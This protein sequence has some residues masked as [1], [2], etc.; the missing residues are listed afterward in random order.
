MGNEDRLLSWTEVEPRL[1]WDKAGILLGNG[2]SMAISPIF[3]Y[4]SL[5]A[6][7]C[8]PEHA[9]NLR[10]HERRVFET[11]E[12]SNFEEVLYNLAVAGK[13]SRC[14]GFDAEEIE[15]LKDSYKLIRRSLISAVR[16]VHPEPGDLPDSVKER[17]ACHLA[18]YNN[19]YT[20]NYDL[21]IFWSIAGKQFDVPRGDGKTE[22]REFKDFFWGKESVFDPS[23]TDAWG[24]TIGVHFLHGGLHLYYHRL[25]G[26][27][28][29]HRSLSLPP[30]AYF[31][32]DKNLLPL[33]VS[34]GES[35]S[36]M[37]SIRR[38]QY[39]SF[40][41][42]RFVRHRGD[43]VVFGHSLTKQFEDHI[44]EAIRRWPELDRRSH[45]SRTPRTLK[46][47]ILAIS[48]RPN[49]GVEWVRQERLRLL[50]LVDPQEMDVFFFDANTH[51]LAHQE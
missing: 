43:L 22:R 20:T 4:S 42:S 9:D 28:H 10:D 51:P 32:R 1:R 18:L 19:I 50:A 29:K 14:F 49:Q 8:D 25:T 15:S 6:D 23:D 31:K 13:T 34:E 3:G 7:A 38:N 17:T 39:L 16:R 24:D 48:I 37:R 12:T 44:V 47:R 2:A 30:L 45:Q 5:Y 36:K 27:T 40:A 21:V 41:H 11:F 26:A 33:F 35:V 46:K